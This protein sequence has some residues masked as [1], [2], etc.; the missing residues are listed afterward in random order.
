MRRLRPG[1]WVQ[2]IGVRYPKGLKSGAGGSGFLG[3]WSL[4]EV[5]PEDSQDRVAGAAVVLRAWGPIC[6]G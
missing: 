6:I 2:E 3:A 4:E 5:P 1:L